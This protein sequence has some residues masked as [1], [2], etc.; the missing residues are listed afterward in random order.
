[1]YDAKVINENCFYED[2]PYGNKVACC[3]V[4]GKFK[5]QTFYASEI[6]MC[7]E[8]DKFNYE[9]GLKLAKAKTYEK[10]F[11]RLK[12]L[13]IA[14]THRPEWKK[15]QKMSYKGEAKMIDGALWVYEKPEETASLIKEVNRKFKDVIKVKVTIEEE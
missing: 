4:T 12:K 10:F 7:E 11:H 13:M 9:F 1:M 14:E 5:S 3:Y 6:A 15:K 8:G 2:S